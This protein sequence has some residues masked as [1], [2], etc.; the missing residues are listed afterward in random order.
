MAAPKG[1]KYASYAEFTGRPKIYTKEY[2]DKETEALYKWCL[3]DDALILREFA[4]IRGFPIN[5]MYEWAEQNE[6]F[7]CV[8]E[9]AKNIIGHRREQREIDKGNSKPW[10]KYAN[11]HD[12]EIDKFEK[13]SL[14]Y[15]EGLKNNDPGQANF[16]KHLDDQTK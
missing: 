1:N 13:E 4:S 2:I 14:E 11:W 12:G 6:D 16:A 7:R 5:K 15:R 8:L 9:Y 3:T 10:D